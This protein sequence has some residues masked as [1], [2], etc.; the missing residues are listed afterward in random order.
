M[1]LD[2][3]RRVAHGMR[4]ERAHLV[5]GIRRGEVP[6]VRLL[7][8]AR[9]ADVRVVVLAEAVPG[10]GKVQARRIIDGLGIVG[11][12]RWSELGGD[13]ARR[14]IDALTDAGGPPAAGR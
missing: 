11:P 9:A 3:A 1:T 7:E 2:S 5:E 6:P 8:D 12:L 14:L 4:A 10:V 13:V